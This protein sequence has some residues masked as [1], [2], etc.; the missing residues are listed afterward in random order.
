MSLLGHDGE[1]AFKQTEDGLIVILPDKKVSEFTTG[2]K[3]IGTELKPVAVPPAAKSK[4]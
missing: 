2:L 3:I 1:I 4:D